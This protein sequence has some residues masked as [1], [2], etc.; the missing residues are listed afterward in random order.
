M[1]SYEWQIVASEGEGQTEPLVAI[2]QF[3]RSHPKRDLDHDR[4][5]LE[6]KAK[7]FDASV[8]LFACFDDDQRV[9]GYAPFFVH[10]GQFEFSYAGTTL[11][12]YPIRRY[13]ITAQPLIDQGEEEGPAILRAL[14]GFLRQQ[15][16]G[17]DVA[18]VLGMHLDSPLGEL[19][20]SNGIGEQFLLKK[21]GPAYH[22]RLAEIPESLDAYY[23]TLGSK[24]RQDLRRQERR[25]LKQAN[26]DIEVKIYAGPESISAFLEG[27][28]QVSRLTYQWNLLGMGVKNNDAMREFLERVAELDCLRGYLLLAEGEPIAFMIGYLYSGTYYSETIGYHPKWAKWSAGNVLHIHVMSDLAQLEQEVKWFDFLYGDNSNKKRLSTVSHEEQNLYLVPRSLRWR[29]LLAALGSFDYLTDKLSHLLER[30]GLKEKIRRIM[31][32]RSIKSSS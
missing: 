18:F 9:I 19:V 32:A 21:H 23:A 13:S 2:D 27:V 1:E 20:E 16:R 30:Y 28:E 10:K 11:W 22:R 29:V 8:K 4:H 7:A 5:W 6:A 12:R 26:D 3:L 15:L 14:L 24:T 17:R 25:L 31:R